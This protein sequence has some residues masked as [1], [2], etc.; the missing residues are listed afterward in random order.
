MGTLREKGIHK[1]GHFTA[2]TRTHS[3]TS[4]LYTYLIGGT[5]L[6]PFHTLRLP[7]PTARRERGG[8]K[9]PRESFNKHGAKAISSP[10]ISAPAEREKQLH[11]TCYVLRANIYNRSWKQTIEAAVIAIWSKD[12]PGFLISKRYRRK[13]IN[14]EDVIRLSTVAKRQAHSGGRG[15]H[16]RQNTMETPRKKGKSFFGETLA[17]RPPAH[18][19]EC[20]CCFPLFL[21]RLPPTRL[22]DTISSLPKGEEIQR[23]GW[24]GIESGDVIGV[25]RR[26][27]R[28]GKSLIA[29]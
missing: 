4:V 22:L 18:S 2:D 23:K 19:R 20:C 3:L 24:G 11:S 12:K 7:L 25:Q 6:P 29:R 8:G 5:L 16:R 1:S 9:G 13:R 28:G 26:G 10:P 21:L 15:N 27:G 14:L 17:G